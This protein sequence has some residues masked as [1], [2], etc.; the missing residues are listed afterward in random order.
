[1]REQLEEKNMKP[2]DLEGLLKANSFV[3]FTINVSDGKSIA[4][5]RPD[6]ALVGED[7]CVIGLNPNRQ[8]RING[9]VVVYLPHVTSVEQVR[10]AA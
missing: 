8:G 4:V 2:E 10:N 9:F 7:H 3:P 5:T 6:Q 1:M